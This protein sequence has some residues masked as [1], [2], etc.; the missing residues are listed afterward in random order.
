[1]SLPDPNKATPAPDGSAAGRM[2]KAS[3]AGVPLWGPQYSGPPIWA[4]V[5]PG[6]VAHLA[7]DDPNVAVG[8]PGNSPGRQVGMPAGRI[9]GGRLAGRECRADGHGHCG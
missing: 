6:R 8:L 3:G 4:G 5:R 7:V 9:A 1:M 2:I